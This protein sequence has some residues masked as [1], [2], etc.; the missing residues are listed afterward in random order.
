MSKQ[1]TE[2]ESF[3]SFEIPPNSR[4]FEDEILQVANLLKGIVILTSSKVIFFLETSYLSIE[5][6]VPSSLLYPPNMKI[7]SFSK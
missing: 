4:I 7:V 2:S 5:L 1:K 6:R 3:V